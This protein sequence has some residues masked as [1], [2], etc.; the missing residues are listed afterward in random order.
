[1][2]FGLCCSLDRL[3]VAA[4]AGADYVEPAVNSTGNP[5]VPRGAWRVSLARLHDAG[6]APEAWNCLLPGDLMVAGPEADLKRLQCYVNAVAPRLDEAGARVVVFGSGASRTAPDGFPL[7][8]G[9]AQFAEAV[10]IVAEAL[11]PAGILVCVEP[12]RPAETNVINTLAEGVAFVRALAIPNVR[13]T[14]DLYH[15]ESAGDPIDLASAAPFIGHAHLAD[16]GRLAPRAGSTAIPAFLAE[17]QRIGYSER[18]SIECRWIDFDREAAPAL[19]F[20]R[21]RAA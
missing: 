9:R 10:S 20:L 15:M 8:D 13:L 3:P 11:A 4:A 12:L 6:I 19:A 1:M 17:L 5:D 21:E 2:R 7:A 16:S 18:I 14:A